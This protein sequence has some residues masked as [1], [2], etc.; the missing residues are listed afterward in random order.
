MAKPCPC[1]C[2]GIINRLMARTVERAVFIESLAEPCG[3]LADLWADEAPQAASELRDFVIEGRALA[4]RMLWGIHS[5]V[6]FTMPTAR[7]VG[8]WE[9]MALRFMKTAKARDPEWFRTWPG[10]VRNRVTGKGG[11]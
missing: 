11:R 5:Q 8:D 1:G 9:S 6:S 10:L 4:R 3:H 7:E 2:G